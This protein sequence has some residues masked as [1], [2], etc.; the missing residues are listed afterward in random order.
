FEL[1]EKIGSMHSTKNISRP[2]SNRRLFFIP[3]PSEDTS[4]GGNV[5]SLLNSKTELLQYA[6]HIRQDVE[7]YILIWTTDDSG[8]Q[9]VTNVAEIFSIRSTVAVIQPIGVSKNVVNDSSGVF[10]IDTEDLLQ[11]SVRR[12]DFHGVLFHVLAQQDDFYKPEVDVRKFQNGSVY[13]ASGS[14]LQI[15]FDLM[16]MLNLT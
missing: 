12:K 15:F 14:S 10:R 3:W 8:R 13:F 9:F 4:G 5:L 6:L 1:I 2:S 7:V 16:L 11:L